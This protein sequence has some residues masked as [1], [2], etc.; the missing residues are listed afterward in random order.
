[1]ISGTSSRL[2]LLPHNV[3]HIIFDF[4]RALHIVDSFLNISDTLNNA[5]WTYG[6]Y[7]I[8]FKSVRK[9][10]FDLVCRHVRPDQVTALTLCD[11]DETPNQSHIFLSLF[12]I[13]RFCRLRAL[14]L[15]KIDTG[16]R[17]PLADLHRL[18]HLTSFETDSMSLLPFI[19]LTPKLE[20]LVVNKYHDDDYNDETFLS[21]MSL[22]H[23]RHLS[24][25]YC[26]YSQLRHILSRT[27]QLSSLEITLQ[28]SDCA[29]IDYFSEQHQNSAL[30]LTRLKM[31]IRTCS[32]WKE[33]ERLVY[34]W[35][36]IARAISRLLFER[37]LSRLPRLR[38]LELVVPSGGSVNLLDGTEWE[39]FIR[40]HLPL[41]SAFDFKFHIITIDRKKHSTETVLAPFRK[42]F[43]LHRNEPWYV[44]YNI[45]DLIL[46]TVP[47]FAPRSIKHSFDPISSH[48]M[49]LPVEKQV[50]LYDRISDLELN[51]DSR[52]TH[53]YTGIE[54]LT[55]AIPYFDAAVIDVTRVKY[56]CVKTTALPLKR[57]AQLIE[58]C[59][60][61]LH[62]LKIDCQLHTSK[63]RNIAPLAQ[64]R[65]LECPG[66]SDPS[67]DGGAD[68]L[69]LFPNVE[70]LV[71][72]LHSCEQ[73]VWL[74]DRLGYLSS[75]SFQVMNF[76]EDL[77]NRMQER[78]GL[79]QWLTSATR[80][81]AT[82]NNFTARLD[83]KPAPWINLWISN[84]QSDSKCVR[85]TKDRH[86]FA[87]CSLQ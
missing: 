37:F 45:Q 39:T 71:I 50:K 47:H 49:T 81:L 62:H 23:L 5:L 4:L 36:F 64:I 79:H 15:I 54:S 65:I 27:P 85:S 66:F 75:A 56:L 25:P 46:Y 7:R 9:R 24:L 29:G 72:K 18:E 58:K 73:M 32:K 59:M 38:H 52:S 35:I 70:R 57:L 82:N 61:H 2:D 11:G 17:S 28:I 51:S 31:S 77:A 41:L 1:M 84:D 86:C 43:W 19:E 22:A 12:P 83:L 6:N 13:D 44:A 42:P 10:D 63:L 14:K 76:P 69:S 20:R 68:V 40:D 67:R 80:R 48:A 55:L 21:T 74:I 87:H 53:R 34:F 33:N 60:P 78:E 16:S 3:I 26:S 8:D 30:A